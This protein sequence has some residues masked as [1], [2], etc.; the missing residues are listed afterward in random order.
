MIGGVPPCPV[1]VQQGVVHFGV[2]ILEKFLRDS[3]FTELSLPGV[4]GSVK[5][6]SFVSSKIWKWW[7][8]IPL[9]AHFLSCSLYHILK[10]CLNRVNDSNFSFLQVAQCYPKK[11]NEFPQELMT[12]LKRHATVLHPEMRM[13]LVKA[14]VLLR[15]KNLL[16]PTDLHILFFQL[17]RCQVGSF[18]CYAQ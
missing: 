3:N 13:S 8:K 2:F 6:N 18:S 4:T 7:N 14:L 12:L 15:N 17:L 11:L 9:C 1:A 10:L 16:S 5:V